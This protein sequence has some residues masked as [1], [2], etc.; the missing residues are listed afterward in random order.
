MRVVLFRKNLAY[1]PYCS[2][3]SQMTSQVMTL[4]DRSQNLAL[5]IH[6]CFGFVLMSFMSHSKK[7]RWLEKLTPAM[8]KKNDVP[9]LLSVIVTTSY[10]HEMV[11]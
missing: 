8:Q 11:Q 4:W 3:C 10:A 2:L 9:R 1:V 6:V 7:K 5:K